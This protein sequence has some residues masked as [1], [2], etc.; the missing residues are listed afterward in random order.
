MKLETG[1]PLERTWLGATATPRM[2]TFLSCRLVP[3]LVTCTSSFTMVFWRNGETEARCQRTAREALPVGAGG[4][5]QQS[6]LCP[7]ANPQDA[8]R[9]MR[10]GSGQ[11]AHRP[12]SLHKAD[13]GTGGPHGAHQLGQVLGLTFLARKMTFV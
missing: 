11:L 9:C 5:G 3:S 4:S 6:A 10:T 1:T 7:W 12:C 8:G 2:V 13:L